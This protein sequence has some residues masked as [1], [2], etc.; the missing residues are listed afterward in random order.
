MK[1]FSLLLV[2]LLVTSGYCIITN[3]QGTGIAQPNK[4]I[5]LQHLV[6]Y[7]FQPDT[8]PLQI[9]TMENML[10]SLQFKIPGILQFTIGKPIEQ[11]NE[12]VGYQMGS[13][14]LFANEEAYE[15][16]L[17][18]PEYKKVETF[19]SLFLDPKNGTLVFSYQFRD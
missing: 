13:T 1:F 10:H 15:K 7:K 19:M 3:Q 12:L 16:Y 8:P 6:L 2:L 4:F 5:P 11:Q 9:H 14:T 18:H 17:Q